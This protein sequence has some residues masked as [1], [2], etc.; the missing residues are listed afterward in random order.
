MGLI[1]TLRGTKA[2]AA[3]TA[4]PEVQLPPLSHPEFNALMAKISGMSEP[5]LYASQPNLHAVIEFRARSTAHI[6]IHIFERQA[7]G[8]RKRNFDSNIAKA[9]AAPNPGM[10]QYDLKESLAR[11]RM[12]FSDA[13]WLTARTSSGWQF[14]PLPIPSLTTAGG[15]ELDG[16]LKLRYSGTGGSTILHQERD[17]VRFGSQ[18]A[19]YD[20]APV[21]AIRSLKDLLAEQVA[22]AAFRQKMWAGGGTMG[23]YITRPADAKWA[24]GARNRFIESLKA[25]RLGGAKAGGTLLLEEGMTINQ[26]RFTAKEEQWVEAAQLSLET[27]ARAF[28][29][30]PTMVGSA[31][32]APYGSIKEFKSMLLTE[33]LGPEFAFI[34]GKLNRFVIPRTDPGRP[35]LYAEFNIGQKLSGSF[36]EQALVLN[37]A[38]GGAYMSRNEARDRL[39]LPRKDGADDLIQPAN[40][41]AGDKPAVPKSEPAPVAVTPGVKAAEQDDEPVAEPRKLVAS[42]SEASTE[43]VDA[44]WDRFMTRQQAAVLSKL[45][46]KASASF[47]DTGRWNA[48]LAD[49]LYALAMAVTGQVA[50]D[51]LESIGSSPDSY[52]LARTAAFLR[53]VANTRAEMINATTLAAIEAALTDA[54]IDADGNPIRTPEK[55]F[56]DA[57]TARGSVS[58]ALLVTTLVGFALV[59]TGTQVAGNKATKT[60]SVN[61]RDPRPEHAAIAGQTVPVG[62]PFSNGAQWPGDPVLGADGNAGCACSVDVN[63]P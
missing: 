9:L 58:K 61:S 14:R 24:D 23:A 32:G 63:I 48:E 49:E 27:V 25:F 29:V 18:S 8:G 6:G 53:A 60:W 30:N 46:A 41:T 59:E 43:A 62:Q 44:A 50:A 2:D 21:S 28:H 4:A 22:A 7:D 1:D 54:G 37:T 52:D 55:V 38:T 39:N 51:A 42:A 16:D 5:E 19:Y 40:T 57:K 36:E 34:E 12:L 11:D 47:W 10:S 15:S 17:F 35:E 26:S 13:V 33:T 56:E 31:T 45:G 3:W 20:D